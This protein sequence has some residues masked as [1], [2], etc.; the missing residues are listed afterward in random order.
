MPAGSRI[1][2]LAVRTVRELFDDGCTQRAAAISCYT[3]LSVFPLVILAVAV[4]GAVAD[5]QSVRDRVIDF[6]L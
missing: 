6:V 3:L 2:A 4:L 5:T 1:R